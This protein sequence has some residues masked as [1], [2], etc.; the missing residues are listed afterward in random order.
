M[1]KYFKKKKRLFKNCKN[2]WKS[3]NLSFLKK[4]IKI[5]LSNN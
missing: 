3:N 2:A 4:K 1:N 5:N